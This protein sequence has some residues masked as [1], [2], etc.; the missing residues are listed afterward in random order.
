MVYLKYATAG[1]EIPLGYFLDSTDGNTEETGL[2]I[3]NT[4]IKLWKNGSSTVANKNSGGA[5]HISNGIYYATLDDTDTNTLGGLVIFSHVSGALSVRLECCVL[6]AKIYDSWIAGTDYQEVDLIQ[7]GGGTQSGTDLKDLV[8][9][10]YDPSSHKVQGVVL[11]DTTTAVTNELSVNT[12]KI[13]GAAVN[14][15]T[16]QVGVNVV[17]QANIDFGAL[18]KTSLNAATPASVV[19]AVGSVTGAV[20]SVTGAVGSVTG[21]VGSVTAEVTANI[22]KIGGV[23]Q[24]MTDL[25]DFVDTGYDP[26]TH[27]I[28]GVVLTDTCTT[29][30][31]MRGTNSAALASV[32]TELRLAELDA[33][34]L[35]TDISTVSSAITGLNDMSS[36][37]V[38]A[39]CDTA[40]SANTDINNIDTGVNTIEGKLPTHYI[41][42]SSVVTDKD[43]EIDDIKTKTDSL[44]FTTANQVDSR[45]LTNSDKTGYTASTVS[46]KTGYSLAASQSGVTIGTVTTLTNGVVVTTNNDKT[47]YALSATGI[48][49]IIDEVLTD[50]SN[51]DIDIGASITLRKAVRAVFNRFYRK[52]TQTSSLQTVYNDSN[53]AIA[54]M[55][56]SDDST[57]QTKATT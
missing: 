4:D 40:I 39:A 46:D 51:T 18:Q 12:T 42:G 56:V 32:C 14:T 6:P 57:T 45:V 11:T 23:A 17:T 7:I 47:G 22:T 36:S 1:Q 53:T 3:A 8:D 20:G 21:A 41:M 29:N 28:Q 54:D 15:G 49:S 37:E 10:G 55:A 26:S 34:N 44:T 52:V 9:T 24:S 48:D 38:Q 2:T 5:S 43:D 13:A 50:L 33:A 30:T 31:D 25:K 16:A 35:P 19:G 27:K